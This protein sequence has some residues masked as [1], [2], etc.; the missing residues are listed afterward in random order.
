MER[1]EE[2]ARLWG[3]ERKALEI[4]DW[5]SISI[6]RYCSP[7]TVELWVRLA[8]ALPL[9]AGRYS[10]AD[11]KMPRR[12]SFVRARTVGGYS[13]VFVIPNE[14]QVKDSGVGVGG[15]RGCQVDVECWDG[16]SRL[17]KPENNDGSA[18]VKLP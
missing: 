14:R 17:G 8:G 1:S 5:R 3:M 15:G 13:A 7:N 10:T 2:R 6:T 16:L 18:S 4:L 9:S 11:E 12:V